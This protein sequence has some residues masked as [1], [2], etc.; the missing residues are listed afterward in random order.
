MLSRPSVDSF[1]AASVRTSRF[2]VSD[3][4]PH[5]EQK[6]KT[7][8]KKEMIALQRLGT[9]LLELSA[10]Q[11]SASGIDERL[12]EAVVSARSMRQRG[13]A[14][15]RQLQYIGRLMREVDAEPVRRA[16]DLLD[17]SS[18]EHTRHFHKLERWR[19]ELL[20]DSRRVVDEIALEHPNLDRQALRSLVRNAQRE[21][22]RSP[23]RKDDYRRLFRFLRSL[24]E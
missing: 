21:R 20:E 23:D 8:R 14:F 2:T 5:G 17:A 1:R 7:Q 9:R 19:D 3:L 18:T 6:S 24:G 10:A 12:Q 4:T 13:R 22:E 16:I 15:K 11:L